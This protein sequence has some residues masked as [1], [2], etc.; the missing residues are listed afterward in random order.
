MTKEDERAQYN[1]AHAK[2]YAHWYANYG[3]PDKDSLPIDVE[4][5]FTAGWD[6]AIAA[7][8]ATVK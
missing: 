6:A 3:D 1:E 5:A 8:G 7:L 4:E 2:W